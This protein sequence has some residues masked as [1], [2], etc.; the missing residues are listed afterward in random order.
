MQTTRVALPTGTGQDAAASHAPAVRRARRRT[1]APYLLLAPTVIFMAIFF[2]WPML[3]AVV[4]A[5]QTTSGQFSLQPVQTMVSDV[6]FWPSIRNTLLLTLVI[7]PSQVVLALIMA[8]LLM[9]GLRGSGALL[10]AW[11]IPLAISDL[12]AG[13]VWFAIFT[14]N[15]YV[16][17][18]LNAFGVGPIIFLSYESPLALFFIV[19]IAEAWRATAIVM[20]ILV[21]GLQ[22][23]PR[24]YAEAG[25]VFGATA[26]QRL[27]YI[28]LPLLKPSLQVA[29]ILRTILAFQMFAVVI[30]LAGRNLPVLAGEAYTWYGDNHNVGVAAAYSLLI[31]IFSLINTGIFVRALRVQDEQARMV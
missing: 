8:L 24:D 30:A 6:N 18:V 2:L 26:W 16:N 13:I 14:Q 9:A 1:I 31:M 27:R 19:V 23:I 15:G 21:A 5:F 4:L 22:V 28:T 29:L 10:Y 25:E 3:Q 11:A 7:V 12:A 20:V 17:S